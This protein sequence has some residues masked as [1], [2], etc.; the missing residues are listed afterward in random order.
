MGDKSSGQIGAHLNCGNKSQVLSQVGLYP[1]QAA[2]RIPEAS[3][4]SMGDQSET[5]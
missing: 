5:D 3:P 4:E 2:V 1:W